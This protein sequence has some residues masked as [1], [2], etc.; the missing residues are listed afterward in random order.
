MNLLLEFLFIVSI[1]KKKK[2]GKRE[3]KHLSTDADSSTD[4]EKISGKKMGG[5]FTPKR[6]FFFKIYLRPFLSNTVS[7]GF[8][9]SKKLGHWTS[10][11]GGQKTFNQSDQ[12]K[13]NQ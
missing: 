2:S 3:T 8:R 1:K 4:T 6:F 9:K 11:R 7:Q 12:M 10:G 13:K 5:N